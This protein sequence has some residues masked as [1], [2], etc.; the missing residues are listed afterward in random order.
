MGGVPSNE[1]G[2]ALFDVAR[3]GGLAYIGESERVS[4]YAY[5]SANPRT[6]VRVSRQGAATALPLRPAGYDDP[7][8]S[9]DGRRLA[10]TV[11]EHSRR[12]IWVYD[13]DRGSL[14]QTTFDGASATPVW[15]PDGR[16][17]VFWSDDGRRNLFWQPADRSS[18]P[19][20]LLTN[21][22]SQW[23]ASIT[24]DGRL[25]TFM[26]NDPISDTDLWL[27]PLT[28]DR[29]PRPLVTSPDGRWVVYSSNE[30][31]RPEIFVTPLTGG[32]KQQVSDDGGEE[33]LWA[34][35]GREL[36]YRNGTKMMAVPVAIG[37]KFNAGKARV[38][39]DRA[40]ARCCPGLPQYD[41]DRDDQSFFMIQD[42]EE[43]RVPQLS[44]VLHWAAELARVV[45]P[46]ERP[47]FRP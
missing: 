17:I 36:F 5:G 13:F 1:T 12:N 2:I 35:S 30:T 26:Q 40:Y 31:G 42:A 32:E 20:R 45:P 15:T 43:S 8:L 9:P 38:L 34:R 44:V 19:E 16:R 33:A 3:S 7:R 46:A 21:P 27:L 10:L 39:F 37:E 28:G 11:R 18:T 47:Q 23:P 41:V 4:G 29:T 6:L 14:T 22:N 25:L 24:P